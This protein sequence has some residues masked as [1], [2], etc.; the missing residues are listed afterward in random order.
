MSAGAE[1]F[2]CGVCGKVFKTKRGLLNH[3]RVHKKTSAT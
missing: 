1:E 2:K 3:M